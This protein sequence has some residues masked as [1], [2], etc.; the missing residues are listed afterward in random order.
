M[1]KCALVT[2]S[3]RGIGKAISLKLSENGFTVFINYLGSE[4][5]AKETVQAIKENKGKACLI[6]GDVTSEVDM[7]KAAEEIS[8]VSSGRLDLLVNNA[9]MDIPKQIENFSID[10]M[11][12]VIDVNLIGVFIVT[13]TFLSLLK[14]SDYPSIINIASRLGQEKTS[15]TA[16]AY[17]PAKA[18]VI[19]FT[20]CCALEFAQ[21]GIRVNAILP[22]LTETDM[23]KSIYS[24]DEFWKEAALKNPRRRVGKPEDIANV[25]SFLASKEADYINGETIGVN[26]GSNLV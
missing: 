2:G 14:K 7:I 13:K 20:K 10:E 18:G 6:K 25:V 17:G 12:K 26:G 3:S 22:G 24:E 21:Y 9:G 4:N 19:K 8:T 16:G 5:T 23:T 1:E 15:A 11:R